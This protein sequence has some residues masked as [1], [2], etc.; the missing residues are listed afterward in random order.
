VLFEDH[1]ENDDQQAK[2]KHKD[3]NPVDRIHVTN[4]T[5]GRFIWIFFPDIEIF[6]QFA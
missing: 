2:Q 3:R 1:P 4:P 6:C 5:A